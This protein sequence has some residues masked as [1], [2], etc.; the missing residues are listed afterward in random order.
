MRQLVAGNWKM[1]L[2]REEALALA[3]ELR[4]GA[5]DVAAELVICPPFTTLAIVAQ[6][7]EGSGMGIGAQDC[8]EAPQGA[9]TGDI[10]AP[11]LRDAGA[12]WVILGHSERRRDHGETDEL[13]REKVLAAS[14]SGLTPVVCVGETE[15][16]RQSGRETEFVGWQISGSLPEGFGQEGGG[17][18][19]YEPVWAIGSGRTPTGAEVAAMH[20]FIR[21]ELRR[22]FG[23]GGEAVRVL[24]G[25][26][27]KPSN[28]SLLLGIANVDG[29]LI[30]GASLQAADFLAIARA[31][32]GG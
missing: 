32:K 28:A 16:Q 6:S 4:R 13:V 1:H 15:E 11:M 19:A 21:E 7:L 26:S 30:G 24:Y 3:Q 5:A 8:H 12:H 23:A 22:Q 25:G 2:L 9:H 14:A 18:I 10:S 17:V 29:A 31:A 27:V 20:A